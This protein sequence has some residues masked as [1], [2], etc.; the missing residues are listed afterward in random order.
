[1]FQPAKERKRAETLRKVSVRKVSALD[2]TTVILD[3]QWYRIHCTST[4]INT[5]TTIVVVL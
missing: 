5:T 4:T 1:M 3:D 2:T